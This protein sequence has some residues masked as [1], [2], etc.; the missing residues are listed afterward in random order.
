LPA[1]N[2]GKGT[3]WTRWVAGDHGGRARATPLRRSPAGL[4]G[5]L[6]NLGPAGMGIGSIIG[7]IIWVILFGWWLALGHLATGIALCITI[8]GI[9]LGIASFKIIPISLVPLGVQIIPADEPYR[10]TADL[11]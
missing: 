11:A 8:I 4:P 2:T 1:V 9:P 10:A 7:D 6:D 3:I 5:L